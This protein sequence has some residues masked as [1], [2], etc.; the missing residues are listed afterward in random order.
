MQVLILEAEL[1]SLLLMYFKNPM[2]DRN[3]PIFDLK[4]DDL[5]S[6]DRL[7]LVIRQEQEISAVKGRLHTT[8]EHI[9]LLFTTRCIIIHTTP[10]HN[11]HTVINHTH[12]K[13]NIHTLHTIYTS[14]YQITHY[15][16]TKYI[17]LLHILNHN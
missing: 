7:T 14:L 9:T 5:S 12:Y 4:H 15:T 3:I 6:S 8:T 17:M 10:K 16:T 2:N 13:S 11:T 1:N